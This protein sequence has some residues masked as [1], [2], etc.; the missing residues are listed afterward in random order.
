V[1]NICF[2]NQPVAFK[3]IGTSIVLSRRS[4]SVSNKEDI[5]LIPSVSGR[6][7]DSTD[8][9]PLV[10]ATIT[11]LGSN[12]SAIADEQGAFEF[13]D[14][15]ANTVLEFSFVG[16]AQMMV[17][18]VPGMPLLVRL[19]RNEVLLQT[20]EISTGLY[21]RPLETF[22][23]ASSVISGAALRTINPTNVMLALIAAE[24]ALRIVEN[25]TL[26]SDPN[27]LPV[28]QL[29][30]QNNL[31]TGLTNQ[32]S[33]S[34]NRVVYEGDIMSAYLSNPNQP[35]LVLDGFQ[36]TLQY[37]ND[38]DITLIERVTVLKDA[39]ATAAYGSRAANGVIV[40]ETKRPSGK[41]LRLNYTLGFNI[42]L[43]DLSSYKMMKA[44]DFLEAQRLS[45]I[46]SSPN[47]FTDI[48]LQ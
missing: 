39:A 20:I 3:I 22:T 36:T 9:T 42:S 45:G 35:L 10:G 37:L 17:P 23:G 7:V 8:G 16:Y 48:G 21:K 18:V 19:E 25:N 31:P 34:P 30:G 24:P 6:V 32:G 40:I 12:W 1:L 46:Y 38:M 29:R 2:S 33:E 27:Y 47:D 5:S 44:A 11:V 13:K 4:P 15:P 28:I 26:G 14:L 41:E 43:A